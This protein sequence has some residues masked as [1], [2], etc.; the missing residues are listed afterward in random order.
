MPTSLS[1]GPRRRSAISDESPPDD[2]DHRRSRTSLADRL[3]VAVPLG[4]YFVVVLSG[5]TTSSLGISGLRQDPKHPLGT[6]WGTAR[7]VRSDEFLTQTSLELNVLSLGHSSHSPLARTPDLVF[8]LSSGQPAET[9]FFLEN[10]LLRLGPWL[11]DTMLFAA[12]RALPLL[13]LALTL[14]RLLRRLGSTRPLSWLAY[15]LVVLA[16]TTLWWSFTPAR[17]LSFASLGGLLLVLAKDRWSG[18][19]TPLA[20]ATALGLAALGGISLARLGTFYVPWSLTVGLPLAVAVAALLVWGAPRRPGLVV[21]ATGAVGGGVLLGLTFWE[22]WDA[23]RATLD[24]AYPGLRRSTGDA[25]APF[26]L[27]GAPGL[28][29]MTNG[30]FPAIANQSEISSAFLVCGLWAGL[31]ALLPRSGTTAQRAAI[32]G[33]AL[34]VGVWVLWC[35]VAWGGPGAS[36]PLLNLVTAPRAA[37]TAGYGAALLLCLVLSRADRVGRGTALAVAAW[38]GL[39]TAYGVT[40]LRAALP[41]L[42]TAEVWVSSL[43]VV[44]C[45]WLVTVFPHRWQAVVPVCLVLLWTGYQVN[46]VILGL[47]DLRDSEAAAAA[48]EIGDSAR[49]Q[50]EYVASDNPFVSALLVGNG[51]PSVTGW[52]I[53]GPRADRW[54]LLDPE[55]DDEETWNRGASYLR[56]SF[57]AAAGADPVISNPNPDIVQVSVDPCGIPER[58]DI[59]VLVS[60]AELDRPCLTLDTTFEWSGAPQYVY[61]VTARG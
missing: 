57:D 40:N 4:V 16:P 10:T 60:G 5:A 51:A 43:V 17:I 55:G 9:L 44:A 2:G 47:G 25:L 50:G 6:M 59:G 19:A 30:E 32:W 13:V 7:G 46:P 31:V 18:A 49:K 52:Q 34:V 20:R 27:W 11:P 58:L 8:Q 12:V 33:L 38:C 15:A 23:V 54:R 56:M 61:A 45:V 24:T 53:T 39:L 29:H 21:L 1:S 42:S 36:L 26:H 35:S 14:P 48:R 28:F 3:E 22:N 37:Q 41:T